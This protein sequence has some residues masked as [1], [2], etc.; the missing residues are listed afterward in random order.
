[1]NWKPIITFLAIITGIYFLWTWLSQK[2][3]NP[4]T[5]EAFEQNPALITDPSLDLQYI[6]LAPD[7][8]IPVGIANEIPE[9]VPEKSITYDTVYNIVVEA[10]VIPEIDSGQTIE[11]IIKNIEVI[12][13]DPIPQ[14]TGSPARAT[15]SRI[16]E[17]RERTK[18]SELIE[19]FEPPTA[20]KEVVIPV[21]SESRIAEVRGRTGITGLRERFKPI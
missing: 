13:N 7:E 8:Y 6:P 18:V 1:M 10:P 2:E 19:R 14:A 3:A 20:K 16:A 12:A 4:T 11:E 5:Q 17:V 21:V 9:T 15:P